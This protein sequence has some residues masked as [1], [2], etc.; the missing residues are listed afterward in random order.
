MIE[1]SLQVLKN[2]KNV[3]LWLDYLGKKLKII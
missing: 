2:E 3:K 1:F